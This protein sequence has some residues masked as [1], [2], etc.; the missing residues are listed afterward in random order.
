[1]QQFFKKIFSMQEKDQI[2]TEPNAD[3]DVTET[4][5]ATEQ[6]NAGQNDSPETA[7]NN[8]ALAELQKQLD[9]AKAKYLYLAADFENYKRHTARERVEMIQSAGRDIMSSLL[10]VLD[11]FE[12]AQKNGGLSEGMVLIHNKLVNTLRGKGLQVLD[13]KPGDAFNPDQQEAV[14]EIPAPTEELKGKI[15]DVLEPGYLLGERMIRFAKV[16]TGK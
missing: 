15:V 10:P 14:T 1:M 13:L 2:T 9:D 4:N 16:V 12:R 11:D 3:Q 8:E 5:M 7:G 6:D